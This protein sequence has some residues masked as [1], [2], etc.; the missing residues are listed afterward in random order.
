MW[1]YFPEDKPL[2]NAAYRV[3]FMYTDEWES[4]EVGFAVWEYC[5][6][7]NRWSGREEGRR[8]LYPVEPLFWTEAV[9]E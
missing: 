7:C 9:G 2:E 4:V 1:H 6:C 8:C 3:A 5:P